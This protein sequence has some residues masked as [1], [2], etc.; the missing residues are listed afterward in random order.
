[1]R[2]NLLISRTCDGHIYRTSDDPAPK[3]DEF[4]YDATLPNPQTL[5]EAT[6]RLPQELKSRYADIPWK[7]ISRLRCLRDKGAINAILKETAGKA[8]ANAHITS[9]AKMQK[10]LIRESL[11]AKSD[12]DALEWQPRYMQFPMKSYTKQGGIAA[13]DAWKAVKKYYR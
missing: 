4:L 10:Q 5:S 13:I 2:I 7:S 3:S 11:S 1:M 9:T 8:V 6:Q 12:T